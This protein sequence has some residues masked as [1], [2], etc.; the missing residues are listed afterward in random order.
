MKKLTLSILAFAF[1]LISN[2]Q[3]HIGVE[4]LLEEKIRDPQMRTL[5][6]AAMIEQTPERFQAIYDYAAQLPIASSPRSEDSFT[7]GA[8][9]YIDIDPNNP[10][11]IVV[12]YMEEGTAADYAIF[13]SE[14]AGSTF[15]RSS[16][17]P[18]AALATRYSSPVVLGGGDPVFTIDANGVMHMSWIYLF[19]QGFSLRAGMLYAYSGDGGLTFTVPAGT[20]HEVLNGTLFPT[21]MLDRQWMATD[22]SGGANHNNIYMSAVY[23]GGVMGAAGEVI[24]V[25]YPGNLGFEDTVSVAVP[26][27][28]GEATQFGNVKVDGNG[29]IHMACMKFQQSDGAGGVYYTKST[30]GAATFST[31]VMVG[32]ATTALPNSPD[33]VVH[34]R[35]NSATSLAIDGN[36]VYIAWT[37]MA[38]SDVRGFFV[39]SNDAGSTWSTPYE[40][41]VDLLDATYYHLM[42]NLAADNGKVT[43]SWYAVRK[44]D[45]MT[46]YYMAS[47][48]D[49]GATFDKHAVISS[50]STDFENEGP[51]FYGDYNASVQHGC[52]TYSAW[53]DGRTG[54]PVLYVARVDACNLNIKEVSPVG[55]AMMVEA[56]YPNPAASAEKITIPVTVAK[57]TIL[58][59]E[60]NDLNGKRMGGL[61]LTNATAG[62]NNVSL[63]LPQLASGTYLVKV[64][65]EDGIFATRRLV[66][67]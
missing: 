60:I 59:I 42:P 23:F 50:A 27:G 8:E 7:G 11:H 10:N 65:R 13:V 20:D 19:A 56:I 47:S 37:D 66:V 35:D 62:K 26:M 38:N 3:F 43:I 57:N 24:V 67:R 40:F 9:P 39:R 61:I 48:A 64:S 51:G 1:A 2:A 28:T 31:P 30:D 53:A 18:A 54:N 5:V 63:Q 21:D 44:A 49:A 16:F 22:L 33:H 52:I 32:T 41:G 55:T 12:T 6:E 36:N 15:V 25:K 17:S 29:N 14:D 46:D 45:M 58:T 34:G 4:H